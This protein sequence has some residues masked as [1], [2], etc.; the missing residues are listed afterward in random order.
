MSAHKP[1]F[2]LI[3]ALQFL[4]KLRFVKYDLLCDSA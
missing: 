1:F 3:S 2:Y 4:R